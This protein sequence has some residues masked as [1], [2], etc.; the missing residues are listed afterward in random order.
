MAACSAGG[1][2]SRSEEGEPLGGC[3]VLQLVRECLVRDEAV[4]VKS[5]HHF[6]AL[7]QARVQN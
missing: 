3:E 5:S 7:Y 2:V 1:V 6:E 4:L